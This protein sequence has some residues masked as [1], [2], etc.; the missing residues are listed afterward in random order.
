MDKVLVGDIHGISSYDWYELT[1]DHSRL[2]EKI[3][4]SAYFELFDAIERGEL[5]KINIK[6]FR[7]FKLAKLCIDKFGEYCGCKSEED[8]TNFLFGLKDHFIEYKK[9]KTSEGNLFVIVKQIKDSDFYEVVDGHHRVAMDAVLG[10]HSLYAY[11]IG[12]TF[13]GLQKKLLTVNMTNS[14][15]LYQPVGK[16]TVERWPTIRNCQDRF[17]MIGTFLKKDQSRL[18]NLKLIDIACSYGFFVKAFASLGI[19]T[20]GLEID[21]NA[22]EIG[23]IVYGLSEKDYVQQSLQEYLKKTDDQ[24]DIVCF[25]SI[26]HHFGL[27]KDFGGGGVKLQELVR[28]LDRITKK[29]LFLDSGQNHEYW[30]KNTLSQW[31]DEFIIKLIMENSSFTGFEKLGIDNDNVGK[32][33]GNYN[34][35][36]FVF[37]K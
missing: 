25:F 14:K 17:A 8:L 34:R 12:E 31:D 28:M 27:K 37:K 30:F 3:T 10:K 21:K 5:T 2:E 18:N 20:K 35:S 1:G 22:I 16:A 24:F 11:V 33:F 19:K 7:Y 13:S 32:Y 4:D 9:D 6:D 15:E 36:L 29:Y 23:K 26:L